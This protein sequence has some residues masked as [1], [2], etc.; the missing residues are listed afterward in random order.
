MQIKDIL[1]KHKYL[2]SIFSTIVLVAISFFIIPAKTSSET[3]DNHIY[4]VTHVADGDTITVKDSSGAEFTV[5]YLYFDTPETVKP[6]TPVQCYG[7]EASD[8]N[9]SLLTN[10][11][12]KLE[13]DIEDKDVY[14]RLLR[15][16]YVDDKNDGNYSTMVNK[17]LLED[18]YAHIY[19]S[20][21]GIKQKNVKYEKDFISIE[22][23]AKRNKVGLWGSCDTSAY[24]GTNT[25]NVLAAEITL[26]STPSSTII[27]TIVNSNCVIKGNV[28]SSGKIY[29]MPGQRYYDKTTIESQN[30]DQFFCTEQDAINAGFRK[31]KV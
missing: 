27:S 20:L 15:Y 29:H 17:L 18:G 10:K 26:T 31:S 13:K 24:G 2:V 5:R 21:S 28:S 23:T 14:N 9:K 8:F 6:N 22:N 3:V 19:H 12:V 25:S 30:G 1:R 4:T 11:N 16:V 7:K